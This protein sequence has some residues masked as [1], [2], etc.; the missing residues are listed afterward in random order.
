MSMN[1]KSTFVVLVI[2]GL[3][4][5]AVLA[6][7]GELLLL[8]LPFVVYLVV[9]LFVCPDHVDL[10]AKRTISAGEVA[11]GE[12]FT[13]EVVVENRG[14]GLTNLAL[15]DLVWPGMTVTDGRTQ[16]QLALAGGQKAQVQYAARGMRGL[17]SWKTISVKASDPCGL[18]ALESEVP[19]FGEVRARPAAMKL[20]RV[21]IAPRSTLHAPGPMPARLPGAG[22]DFWEVREY[23]AGDP[24]RRL[25][26]R[27]AGRY[28]RR[29]F[30][31]EFEGEEIADYGL[32]LDARRLTNDQDVD[33]ELFE[34]SISAATS[35][36]ESF[37]DQGNRMALLIFGEA[38]V[39]L[40]PGYGKR[41]LNR[42]RQALA[43]AA[44]SRNLP[45]RY[46]ES[47]PARLFPNRSVLLMFSV[48][49]AGDLETYRRLRSFGYEVLLV[50]PNPIQSA[51][52]RLE[53]TPLN[54]LAARAARL[55]RVVQL[56]ALMRIGISVIDWRIDQPLDTLLRR[57]ARDMAH[58]RNL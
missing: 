46:L 52:R 54:S 44:L 53:A 26:W 39:G 45:G 57:T 41:Q 14:K 18:F 4:L 24:L 38:P 51:S 22:T 32:I 23:R 12:P 27:L 20:R 56:N 31:N 30:T 6:R 28:P 11:A 9:G 48:V 17:Y 15:S 10:H 35:L 5:C 47:F 33:E 2:C 36:A 1:S 49:D 43:R 50:S 37:L 19:A 13:V 29:L 42:V 58:R 40:F 3:F 16:Q 34:A 25:N 7:R 55:E 8:A 21:R